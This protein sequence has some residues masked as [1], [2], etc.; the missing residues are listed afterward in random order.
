LE[1]DILDQIKSILVCIY[2]S[3][4]ISG[5]NDTVEGCFTHIYAEDFNTYHED[6]VEEL[7][8]ELTEDTI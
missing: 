7:Y 3:G 4:Y 1:V 2:N 6:I 8:K 5:H